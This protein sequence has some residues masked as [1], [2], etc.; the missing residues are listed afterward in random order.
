MGSALAAI[1]DRVLQALMIRRSEPRGLNVVGT[2][3]HSLS[4]T[5]RYDFPRSGDDF[6]GDKLVEPT[7]ARWPTR[8]ARSVAIGF[9]LTL[10]Q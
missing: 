1:F 9:V 5:R 3:R 6:A 7:P 2:N 8:S 10:A 4:F